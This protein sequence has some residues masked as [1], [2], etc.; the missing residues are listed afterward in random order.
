MDNI[1]L[2]SIAK[3]VLII[4]Q[5]SFFILMIIIASYLTSKFDKK[6]KLLNSSIFVWMGYGVMFLIWFLSYSLVEQ[7]LDYL[8]SICP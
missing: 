6:H 3:V 1:Q 2:V 7:Y 4:W 5:G 8:G